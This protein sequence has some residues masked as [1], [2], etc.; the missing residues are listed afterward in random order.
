VDD[1]VSSDESV[2][3]YVPLL[4]YPHLSLMLQ[5]PVIGTVVGDLISFS[6]SDEEEIDL[7]RLN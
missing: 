7:E 3:F 6:V 4:K 5:A 1:R 2:A